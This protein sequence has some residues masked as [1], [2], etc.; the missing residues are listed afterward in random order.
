MKA[1]NLF[2]SLLVLGLLQYQAGANEPEQPKIP[3]VLI[4]V[5]AALLNAAAQ[6]A[7][8][9]TEPVCEVIQDTPVHGIARSV[10]STWAEL[11]PDD[12]HAVVDVAF[13]GCVWTWGVGSRGT[14][15]IH[16]FT[17]TPLETRR[18]VVVDEAGIRIFAGPSCVKATTELQCIRSTMD[19]NGLAL[20]SAECGYHRSLCAAEA[21]AGYKT[22]CRANERLDAELTP[23]LLSASQTIGRVLARD[24]RLGLTLE[25]LQFKTTP[26]W[27]QVRALV[28]AP[29][30]ELPRAAP[31]LAAD[32]DLG[33]RL[34]ESFLNTVVQAEI[35]GRS[36]ALDGVSKVYEDA[37]RGLL[38][39]AR[40]EADQKASL[41]RIEK[42]AA[43]LAGK[44]VTITLAKN[45]PLTVTFRDQE[46]HIEVHV[47]SVRQEGESFAGLRSK[48]VY[49]LENRKAG[50]QAVRKGAVQFVVD[51]GA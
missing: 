35:G 24:K 27:L 7:V 30:R 38:R 29:G 51:A 26:S 43:G 45:D 39:D 14:I 20:W 41:K 5:S 23:I 15:R 3:N 48:L 19:M 11:V 44:P 25:S 9:R 47:A 50:A 17:T 46:I 36:F 1:H 13:R 4:D 33:V 28:S 37:T 10:G 31:P 8:D 2:L 34:H 32:T 6:Q 49:R 18:R 12:R 21:E 40:P 16:T 42:L 22:V